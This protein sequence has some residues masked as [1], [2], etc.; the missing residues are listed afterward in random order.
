MLF[1]KMF[2]TMFTMIIFVYSLKGMCMPQF[3]WI[4]CC[5]SELHAHLCPN[6]NVWPEA[7]YCGLQELQCLQC[8]LHVDIIRVIG[9]YNFII[10]LRFLVSEIA[11]YIA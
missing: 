3:T 9:I 10:A 1:Y 5:I 6:S 2:T 11:G 4:G 8:C 7:V